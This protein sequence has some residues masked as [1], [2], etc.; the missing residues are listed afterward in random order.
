MTTKVLQQSDVQS[1]DAVIK[2]QKAHQMISRHLRHRLSGA[3][4]S[5][6]LPRHFT[7]RNVCSVFSDEGQLS[8]SHVAE[9]PVVNCGNTEPTVGSKKHLV[10]SQ[11]LPLHEVLISNFD[12]N[13]IPFTLREESVFRQIVC[14]GNVEFS[15]VVA[16]LVEPISPEALSWFLPGDQLVTINDVIVESKDEAWRHICECKLETLKLSLC[17]LVEL[18]ELNAR[19]IHYS[20]KGPCKVNLNSRQQHN[21]HVSISQ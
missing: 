12:V 7:L 2:V 14:N 21:V 9:D 19:H 1:M 11:H 15:P 20:D 17:P 6:P 4:A 18:S 13:N 5:Q 8:N 16:I 3:D 10:T